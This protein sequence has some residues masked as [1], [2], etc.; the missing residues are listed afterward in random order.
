M[1]RGM[2]DAAMAHLARS[3][4]EWYYLSFGIGSAALAVPRDKRGGGR[5]WIVL[6]E[7]KYL[8]VMSDRWFTRAYHKAEHYE[9]RN[10]RLTLH[11]D[12][13]F[14]PKEKSSVVKPN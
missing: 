5:E 2:T 9:R 8:E 13:N 6:H 10:V 7:G 4:G 14:Q 11:P 1:K 3:T 12:D